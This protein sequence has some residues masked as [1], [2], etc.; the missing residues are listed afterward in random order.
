MRPVLA[1]LALTLIAGLA[2]AAGTP[3]GAVDL[4]RVTA[5]TYQADPAHTLVAW[6]V[7]HMGFN[8]Y[9]GLFGA[10]TGTL[11]LDPANPAAARVAV[12]IPVRK[13][14]TA[15]A[16]L[17]GHLLRPNAA[18][19]PDYFGPNPA[20][21]LFTSTRVIPAADGTSARIEGR[22]SLNGVTRPVVL[23]ARFTGA[24]KNPLGGKQTVGFEARTAI[25]RSQFGLTSDL[26]L[27]GD[28]VTLEITAG[29]ERVR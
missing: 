4:A 27:V 10:I 23:D 28:T 17:T 21:A 5:G 25:Q 19:K 14:T 13:I 6:R 11:T 15:N 7:N 16:G 9:F 26:P 8:D 3:P 2:K 29:F 24:G 1:A 12:R 22:L 18:G 20:D